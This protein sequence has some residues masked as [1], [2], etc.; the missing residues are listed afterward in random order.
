MKESEIMKFKVQY[1]LQPVIFTS[2]G[3]FSIGSA[4]AFNTGNDAVLG[5]IEETFGGQ[6]AQS[7]GRP[8]TKVGGANVQKE[9]CPLQAEP[10]DP[11]YDVYCAGWEPRYAADEADAD[12]INQCIISAEPSIDCRDF[13]GLEKEEKVIPCTG[14]TLSRSYGPR[15][16]LTPATRCSASTDV[17]NKVLFSSMTKLKQELEARACGEQDPKTTEGRLDR[18]T[19][20]FRTC[21]LAQ[22]EFYW[23]PLRSFA[24]FGYHTPVKLE[25]E[26]CPAC[27]HLRPFNGLHGIRTLPYELNFVD[28]SGDEFVDLDNVQRI[29]VDEAI[30]EF[31]RQREGVNPT[32]PTKPQFDQYYRQ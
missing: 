29:L 32:L 27:D 9:Q 30:K 21:K 15:V 24:S 19:L 23:S 5:L 16:K 2:L 20:Y 18:L 4:E 6:T 7:G 3:L 28:T 31:I 13:P 11:D 17:G 8:N 10:F 22:H 14:R 12:K 26:P 1:F 25:R